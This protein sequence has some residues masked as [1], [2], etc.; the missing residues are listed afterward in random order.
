MKKNSAFAALAA[1][2]FAFSSM[3]AWSQNTAQVEGKVTDGTKPI[4]NAQLTLTNVDNNRVIKV[5]AD[6]NG[7]FAMLGIPFG[8]YTIDVATATGEKIYSEQKHIQIPESGGAY[9]LMIDTSKS[10]Q[11]AQGGGTIGVAPKYTKEQIDEIQK[12][13]E[14]ATNI[15][16]LI[17]QAQNAMNA[18]QWEQA[19]PLTQQLVAA[20]PTNWQFYQALGN[21]QFNLG[22]FE[23]AADAYSKGVQAAESNTTVD[24]KNPA[25]DPAKKKIGEAQMLT[26]E[27]NADLKIHKNN[28]AVAAFTKAASLDPNPA[29]AYFN[30]C[31]TQYNTGNVDGALVACDKAIAADPNKADAYFIKGSLMIAGSKTEKDGKI[32][33]PPGTAEA[34]NKYLELAPDGP[35]ANDVK[36]MLAY[37]GSKVETTYKKRGK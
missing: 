24:P 35:H 5:K 10:Q 19:L 9:Q 8:N 37:I 30:L 20:E 36:Q 14:K 31:A 29:T 12:Q 13:R 22:H 3:L 33:A 4:A 32:V 34:L 1:L 17:T 7:T 25:T 26:N 11:G 15:N 6:K 27:G 28:E 21:T 2:L 16:A 23:E 18:K